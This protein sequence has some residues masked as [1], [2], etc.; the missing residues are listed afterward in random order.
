R[1]LL[2]QLAEGLGAPVRVAPVFDDVDAAL[3]ASREFGLEG[4]VAKDPESAYREGA[5]SP[6]WLKLKLTRTQEAAIIGIRPGKGDRAGTFG[7]L[8]LAVPDDSGALRYA[9]R[10]GTGFTDRMLRDVLALLQPLRVDQPPV[11]VPPLEAS[12]AL[13][14]RPEQVGEV[15]FANWTP[16]GILRHARWRGLRPDKS[17]S[18]IRRE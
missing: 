14:V 3:A 2:E 18:E 1:E 15:E 17:V 6:A 5:R 11:D 13:W 4:V 9:G 16:G 8:L 12:D 10:V 7:S